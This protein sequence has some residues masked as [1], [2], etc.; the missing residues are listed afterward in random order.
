MEKGISV[1]KPITSNQEVNVEVVKE[2]TNEKGIGTYSITVDNIQFKA[3]IK[4]T[5]KENID[6]SKK[7]IT[8]EKIVFY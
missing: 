1:F 6:Y 7:P 3:E 5:T 8:L 4:T 2:S